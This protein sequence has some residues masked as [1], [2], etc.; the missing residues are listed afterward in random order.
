MPVCQYLQLSLSEC[1]DVQ[2][3]SFR[4]ENKPTNMP[5]VQNTHLKLAKNKWKLSGVT[6]QCNVWQFDDRLS[7]YPAGK[8][9]QM[10]K[11]KKKKKV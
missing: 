3:K 10:Q 11:K 9:A 5:L 1:Q 4:K 6:E 8:K 7:S 2:I